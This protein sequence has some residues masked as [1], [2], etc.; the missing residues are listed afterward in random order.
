M[1][2][3]SEQKHL[4][5]ALQWWNY[6]PISL[7]FAPVQM[8]L[9]FIYFFDFDPFQHIWNFGAFI[10][11][12]TVVLLLLALAFLVFSSVT[13]L[14]LIGFGMY[15]TVEEIWKVLTWPFRAVLDLLFPF[16]NSGIVIL[17]W[18]LAITLLF[19]VEVL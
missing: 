5:V 19:G 4:Q 18:V 1:E 10:I 9:N 7:V 15:Y 12:S 13:P 8:V 11:V 14:V 2:A 17:L 6:F 3:L 16:K